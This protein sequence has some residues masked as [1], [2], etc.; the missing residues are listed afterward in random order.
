M[1]V[2]WIF[3]AGVVDKSVELL[4][5]Q[6]DELTLDKVFDI[7]ENSMIKEWEL[8]QADDYDYCRNWYKLND[9][10]KY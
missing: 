1:L 6:N 5:S 4:S 2:I 10:G 7:V 8:T 9:N 3:F